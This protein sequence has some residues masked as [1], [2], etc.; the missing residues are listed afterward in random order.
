MRTDRKITTDPDRKMEVNFRIGERKKAAG[1]DNY[2]LRQS[3]YPLGSFPLV[4][5]S[6]NYVHIWYYKPQRQ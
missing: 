1:E 3:T 6:Y 4:G 5:V 2:Y